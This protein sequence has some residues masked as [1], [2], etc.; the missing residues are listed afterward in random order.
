[1]CYLTL[2]CVW[3]TTTPSRIRH[4]R[5]NFLKFGSRQHSSTSTKSRADQCISIG[6][7]FQ[8]TQRSKS[9]GEFRH[10]WD[11]LEP[12]DFTRRVIF[13]KF[14]CGFGQERVWYRTSS[15]TPTGEWDRIASKMTQKFEEASHPIFHYAEPLLKG[16]VKSNE[17]KA[18]IIRTIFQFG[19]YAAVC[20]WLDQDNKKQRS[21]SSGTF[22]RRSHEKRVGKKLAEGT[23]HIATIQIQNLCVV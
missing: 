21:L 12:F 5:Q 23:H 15:D 13:D 19:I 3:E 4:G 14:F 18:I 22:H 2:C 8:P 17:G 1:M 20:V 9:R 6:T 7:Y 16:D 10:S 11:P